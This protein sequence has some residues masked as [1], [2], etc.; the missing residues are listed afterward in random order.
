MCDTVNEVIE[1]RKVQRKKHFDVVIEY[2]DYSI[3]HDDLNDLWYL[4]RM[5]SKHV[6]LE[7]FDGS[8]ESVFDV[9]KQYTITGKINFK[10]LD[11]DDSI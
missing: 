1:L 2:G 7:L 10:V 6:P 3:L 5:T 8:M 9:F 11:S 4:G